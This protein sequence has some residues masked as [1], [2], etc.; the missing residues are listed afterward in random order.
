MHT[1]R[2]WYRTVHDSILYEGVPILLW[3]V[4]VKLVSPVIE[5]DHQIL[6]EFDLAQPIEQRS[7]R[8]V[9]RLEQVTEADLE[10]LVDQRLRLQPLP[11]DTQFSDEGEYARA[12]LERERSRL[13][14]TYRR[15][16]RAGE[17]CFAARIGDEYVHSNWIRFH[18]TRPVSSRPVT[19]GPGEAYCIE[20][21]TPQRWR[22]QRFHE[23]V[24][25]CML[26]YAQSRGYRLALTITDLTKAGSRRGLARVGGW[27]KRGHHLLITPRGL[28]RSWMVRLDGDVSP[29]VRRQEGHAIES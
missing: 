9:C 20:G 11:D 16:F 22:G 28:R 17:L 15:W 29:I 2:S 23:A 6:F 21:F 24:H 3:R 19:L 5:L 27:R 12:L 8:I 18:E 7:A 10:R 26:R 13:R 1:L 25:T 4:L 14:D